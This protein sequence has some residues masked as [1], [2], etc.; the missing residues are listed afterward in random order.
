MDCNNNVQQNQSGSDWFT[1]I[2]NMFLFHKY[3]E[4]LQLIASTRELNIFDPVK[5]AIIEAGCWTHL[6]INHAEAVDSLKNIIQKDPQNSFAFYGLGF[7]F[8]MNGKFKESL[9]PFTRAIDLNAKSMGRAVVYKEKAEKICDILAT[10]NI[11]PESKQTF[12]PFHQLASSQFS[13]GQGAQGI[14][15]LS[16]AVLMDSD[17]KSVKELVNKMTV[18]FLHKL[19]SDLEAEVFA[20]VSDSEKFYRAEFLIKVNKL[21]DAEK[22][23]PKRE[24]ANGHE[25]F[26][27]GLLAYM[28]GALDMSQ[29]CFSNALDMNA[30]LNEAQEY[31][32][33][34]EKLFGLIEEATNQMIAEIYEPALEKLNEA[35]QIDPENKRIVQAIYFQRSMCKLKMY[36]LSEAYADYVEFEKLQN[37]TGMIMDGIK[38]ETE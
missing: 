29:R 4:C 28:K 24:P 31:K 5:L 33:K 34:A 30:Q 3:E 13:S 32:Q 37:E 16:L 21:A 18:D 17:N 15:T 22:L 35:I 1:L 12:H 10:G 8:Y 6:G 26:V 7:N 11:C 38:F 36:K 20:D 19:V 27:H 2:K 9:Q 23:I 14:E 25:W